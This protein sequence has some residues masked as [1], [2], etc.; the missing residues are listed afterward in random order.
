MISMHS[1]TQA[2]DI[3]TRTLTHAHTHTHTQ[4]TITAGLHCRDVLDRMMV[5]V[6]A[7]TMIPS[8]DATLTAAGCNA[9]LQTLPVTLSNKRKREGKKEFGAEVWVCVSV[10]VCVYICVRLQCCPA[11][12]PGGPFQQAKARGQKGVWCR[13]VGVCMCL[14]LCLC[15]CEAAMLPC[16]PS[17]WPFPT[18]ESARAKRSLVQR[19]G[20][21]YVFMFVSM[22]V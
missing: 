21:V 22:Y 8:L 11:S 3:L 13:G 16:K 19:C 12:P 17:R 1:F 7:P 14:C 15:M 4:T 2:A 5:G 9:A 6:R 20:C 18:S 10:Y